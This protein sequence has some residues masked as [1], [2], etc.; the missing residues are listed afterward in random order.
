MK[1][2]DAALDYLPQWLAHQM[3]VAEQPGCAIAVA[4]RGRVVFEATFG[5]ADAVRGTPLTPRHRFRVASHSKTFTAAAVMKLRERGRL[6]LDDPVGRYVDRLPRE[7]GALTLAQLLSHS[8]GLVRDGGDARQWSLA[9]AFLD[10]AALRADLEQG[11]TLP[12]ATR[13]KYSNHGYGL[14]G[15]A[16]AAVVQEPYA[17]WVAREIVAASGL[18]ET[19]PDVH[20]LPRGAKLAA[21]HSAKQP[22]GRRAAFDVGMS[23]HALASATGFVATAADLARFFGSLAP[24]ARRS[25]LGAES[26]REMTRRLWKSEH[27]SS[28]RWYG[29]GTIG[30]DAGA[31]VH[32]GHSG[33]FPGVITRTACVPSQALAVSVLTHAADGLAHPWLDGALHVLQAFEKHGAPSR[34]S[35]PW[36]GR[37]WSLWGAVDLLPMA[38]ARVLV[39][40][41]GLANPMLDASEVQITGRDRGEVV[42][43]GGFAFHGE[44]VRLE[45]DG[46]GRVRGVWQGGQWLET[47]SAVKRRLARGL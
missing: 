9:R 18:D 29:L 23:T 20:A 43:G 12:A 13:F 27:D 47:E 21:G 3:R 11:C 7:V 17:D 28:G 1:W 14:L 24:E 45:R 39:A 5:Q 22:L 38:G 10:E 32:F 37:Y 26:R 40:N 16:I 15:L 34:R 25:V 8:A 31:W 35:A 42:R 2:L 33:G 44:P 41:P 30:G 19:V 4:H 6:R 36:R 46:A